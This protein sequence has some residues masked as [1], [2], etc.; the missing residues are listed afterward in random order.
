[1]VDLVNEPVDDQTAADCLDWQ[2][3]ALA[4]SQAIREIDP[5]RTL[6]V[7]PPRWGSAS[8]FEAFNPIPVPRVVYSFHMY[9]PHRFT[10]QR[11][12]DKSQKSVSY[13]GE[14]DGQTWTRE[15]LMKAMQ[16][17]IDFAHRYRVHL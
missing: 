12:F 13:P 16:P 10:H 4:T 7:E 11:V 3:L 1:G 15:K 2:G 6:I 5:N 8:G 9:E 17:A 14:M